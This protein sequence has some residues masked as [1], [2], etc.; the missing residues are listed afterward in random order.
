MTT[1]L[2]PGM[3]R[4]RRDSELAAQIAQRFG[5]APRQASPTVPADSPQ[6]RVPWRHTALFLEAAYENG[7]PYGQDDD[8]DDGL[9]S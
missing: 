5:T 6:P 3:R 9:Q 2:Y 7:Q 4:P 8:E 1:M